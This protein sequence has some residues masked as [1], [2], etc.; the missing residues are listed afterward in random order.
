MSPLYCASLQETR[1]TWVRSA[2]LWHITERRVIIPHRSFRKTCRYHFQP[3]LL[4][5]FL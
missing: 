2:L 1:L 5:G 3:S 4:L